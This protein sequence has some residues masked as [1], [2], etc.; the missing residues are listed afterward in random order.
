MKGIELVAELGRAFAQKGTGSGLVMVRDR[1][2]DKM[3]TVK[4]VVS[5]RHDDADGSTTHWIEVE[6][7]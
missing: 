3:F 6:E 7:Y 1:D 4:G 5:E 2:T